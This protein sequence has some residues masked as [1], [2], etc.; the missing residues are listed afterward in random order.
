MDLGSVVALLV[1]LSSSGILFLTNLFKYKRKEGEKGHLILAIVGAL[2]TSVCIGICGMGLNKLISFSVGGYF[3]I[4]L[5]ASA[6]ALG[7]AIYITYRGKSINN[8]VLQ[9]TEDVIETRNAQPQIRNCTENVLVSMSPSDYKELI[10][11]VEK[12]SKEILLLSKRLTVMFKSEEM[13]RE[14]AKRRFG[15]GSP[16]I[17][18]YKDEHMQRKAAFYRALDDGCKIYEIHNKT[19]LENYLFSRKHIGIGQVNCKFILQMLES[20]KQALQN[21]PENYFVALTEETIAIKYELVNRE[22]MVIHESVGAQ[23][24]QRMNALFIN[25]KKVSEEIRKD[26]FTIWERTDNKFRE[27]TYIINW[28]DEKIRV[29]KENGDR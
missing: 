3:V 29:I 7:F 13:I 14:M 4:F 27:K 18:I 26:F 28:I 25:S 1:F 16:H 11:E 17:A 21:Y 8:Q 15:E 20:W 23:S 6:I 19:E 10:L 2:F 9:K 24:D 22:W 5:V 12:D